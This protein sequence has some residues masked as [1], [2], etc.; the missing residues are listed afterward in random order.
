MT[1]T[2]RQATVLKA[3]LAVGCLAFAGA[4]VAAYSRPATGYELSIYRSTPVGFWIGVVVAG[5]LGLT[6]AFSPPAA[7]GIR[8]IGLGLVTGVALA[9]F[10]LPLVRGYFFY[11]A[12]DSMTHLGWARELHAGT[13]SPLE[14]VYPGI[15]TTA[16]YLAELSGFALTDTLQFVPLVVFPI[17]SVVFTALCVQYLTGNRWGLPVGVA[18][19]LLL[20]PINHLSIHL[21]AHPSSQAV[22]FLPLVL[23]LVLRFVTA[24][25]DGSTLGTPI[26]IALAVVCVAMVFIHPQETLSLLLLLGGI[27]V[28]QLAATRW[29]PTSR[30]ARHRPIYAH[31][32]LTFL[33][34]ATWLPQHDRPVGRIRF[35]ASQFQQVGVTAGAESTDTQAASLAAL[36]GS[37]EELFVKLFGV[38]LLVSV[39]AA[40]LMVA[41][42]LGRLDDR[43]TDRRALVT[44]LTAGLVPLGF[45]FLA[46]FAADQGDH[47]FRFLGFIMGPVTILGAVGIVALVGRVDGV[48]SRR[49]VAAGLVVV[50]TVAMAAQAAAIHPSPYYYQSNGHVTERSMAGHTVAFDHRVEDT[51]FMGT[52]SGPRRYVQTYYGRPTADRVEFPD[53]GVPGPVF[54]TNLSTAYDDDRYLGIQ[55]S[56]YATE[57]ELYDGLRYTDDGFAALERRGN[58][59]RVQDNGG[60]RL[61]LIDNG[62]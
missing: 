4:L 46:V 23:Y 14:F 7:R 20:V 38:A 41:A 3:L 5:V 1:D 6:V 12:G 21:L 15:H 60:F 56:N 16:A 61:Y 54:N 9:V 19:G 49:T 57:V 48:V 2:R 42:L 30:I 36:G 62:E 17:V 27:A 45:A 55:E 51:V 24:P 18:V 58:I 39:I 8:A 32:A 35:V 37:I 40:A 52:R 25:D 33:V 26:G 10:A 11:G 53:V 43:P 29:R 59:Y 22:L 50:L 34:F 47:Y 13:L 31:A 28:V 44:Y